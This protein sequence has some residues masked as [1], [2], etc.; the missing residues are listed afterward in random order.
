M[1]DNEDDITEEI[2]AIV[3]GTSSILNILQESPDTHTAMQTLASA[4]ACV[5]CSV[6]NSEIEAQEEFNL[7]VEAIRRAV[8]RAKENNF[9]VWPAGSSH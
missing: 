8:A 1:N 6:M 4:T 5:L 2:R 9:V 7:F 3:S